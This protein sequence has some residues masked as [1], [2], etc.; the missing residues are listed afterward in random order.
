MIETYW[1]NVSLVS[2][3]V[4]NSALTPADAPFLQ[5][6]NSGDLLHLDQQPNETVLVRFAPEPSRDEIYSLAANEDMKIIFTE[7]TS[8]AG[9]IRA[10]GFRN[11]FA[12]RPE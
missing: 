8:C 9:V 12:E 2:S 5:F 10:T 3:A 6:V 11:S 7:T 1:K 4:H